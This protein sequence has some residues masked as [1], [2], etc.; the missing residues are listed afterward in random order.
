M[1]NRDKRRDEE[2]RHAPALLEALEPRLL[3]ST[4]VSQPLSFTA[5]D[6]P[7]WSAGGAFDKSLTLWNFA[8]GPW[9]V[10]GYGITSINSWFGARVYANTGTVSSA[11]SGTLQLTLP[12]SVQPGQ[13]D[14]PVS[15][16]FV[17]SPGGSMSGAF[18]GGID[19]PLQFG[20]AWQLPWPAPDGSFNFTVNL[21]DYA[22]RLGI[23]ISPDIN[24]DTN[25]SFTP[26]LGTQASVSGTADVADAGVGMLQLAGFI[27][28]PVGTAATVI[29]AFFDINLGL[30]ITLKRTDYFSPNSLSG[31]VYVN[32]ANGGSFSLSS[33][34]ST[35]VYVDIPDTGANSISLDVGDLCLENAFQTKFSLLSGPFFEVQISIPWVY[36]WTPYRHEW[37]DAE[38]PL[39]SLPSKQLDFGVTDP[40]PVSIPVIWAE[41]AVNGNGLDIEDG[42]EAPIPADGTDYGTTFLG[43]PVSHTFRVDNRGSDVLTTSGLE[44][45]G[46][47]TVTEPLS[48]SIA[49]GEYDDFTVT[50]IAT[51]LGTYQGRIIFTNNDADAGD[52]VESPFDFSI[53]GTVR[54]LE[55]L[56]GDANDDGE[57]GIA[58]L[59]ALAEHYGESNVGWAEGD[60]NDDGCVGIAD[61][62]ALADHYGE[63][64]EPGGAPAA[65]GASPAGSAAAPLAEDDGGTEGALLSADAVL[66]PALAIDLSALAP[67]VEPADQPQALG[68]EWAVPDGWD[69]AGPDAPDILAGVLPDLLPAPLPNG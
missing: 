28:A 65:G 57:V 9:T 5:S 55:R 41:V 58:D 11:F 60:F 54:D 34:S 31:N 1:T 46:G 39:I 56:M 37:A 7:I 61:L 8:A 16:E 14:V 2:M 32:G 13:Q 21:E 12:D 49:A 26:I 10:A 33:S 51:T 53:T 36:T 44:V 64:R 27:P 63:R 59:V 40:P 19:I 52:G 20:M 15:I 25:G 30:D 17:P 62:V 50:L 35:T 4:V 42:D 66:L 23:P 45:P 6:V 48:S 18:G 38:F 22:G 29:S 68:A 43:T 47:Y 24:V 67:A 69:L 3:L